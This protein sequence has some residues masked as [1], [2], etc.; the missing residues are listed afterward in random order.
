M[1][2]AADADPIVAFYG[3]GVDHRG[4]TLDEILRW[5]DD[6]LEAVHDYIQWL[7]PTAQAS[8]FNPLAP[9]ITQATIAAFATRAELRDRLASAFD[10]LLSFYGLRRTVSPGEGVLIAIDEGRFADRA[11]TWLRPGNHNHLRLTR[12]MQSL[13]ALGLR[14][15]A[16][17]LQRCLTKDLYEGPGRNRITPETREYWL[18]ALET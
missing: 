6:R 12:I 2:S 18:G 5:S 13:A 3:G 15:E 17:A 10:R 1:K 16:R 8:A 11:R 7:F 4:R 9:L 14:D